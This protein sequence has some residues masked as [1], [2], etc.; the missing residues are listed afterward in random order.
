MNSTGQVFANP[1][2]PEPITKLGDDMVNDLSYN[3]SISE[4]DLTESSISKM[5]PN[6]NSTVKSMRVDR[7]RALQ[8][9]GYIGA[10]NAMAWSV[11]AIAYFWLA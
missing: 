9:V 7:S 6:P 3:V 4:E 1:D 8:F 11:I 2:I 10:L 5:V